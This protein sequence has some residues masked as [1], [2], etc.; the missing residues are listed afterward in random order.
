MGPTTS[1]TPTAP[2]KEL[3]PERP[4]WHPARSVVSVA[5]SNSGWTVTVTDILLPPASSGLRRPAH[6]ACSRLG[7]CHSPYA[8]RRGIVN[9]PHKHHQHPAAG[10]LHA[11]LPGIRVDYRAQPRRLGGD[12]VGRG[13]P[14]QVRVQ[15]RWGYRV[16]PCRILVELLGAGA[17][18]PLGDALDLPLSYEHLAT[19]QRQS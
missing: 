15:R 10:H 3:L 18:R 9:G 5:R 11:D 2:N 16:V 19:I 8:D 1:R 12:V 7:H 14:G 17:G 13:R 6:D 4:A